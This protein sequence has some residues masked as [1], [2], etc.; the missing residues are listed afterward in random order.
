M[1]TPLRRVGKLAVSVVALAVV[2]WVMSGSSAFAKGGHGGGHG[3]GHHGGGHH[4]GGAHRAAGHRGGG[5]HVAAHH[6]ARRGA[7][8]HHV[9][10]HRAAGHQGAGRVAA[11]H[12]VN[13][14]QNGGRNVMA[15]RNAV[16]SFNGGHRA[17]LTGYGFGV[18]VNRTGYGFGLG[19]GYG[20]GYGGN[21]YWRRP[22]YGNYGGYGYGYGNSYPYNNYQYWNSP[23]YYGMSGTPVNSVASDP[24]T[25]WLSRVG[26][27]AQAVTDATGPSVQVISVFAGSPAEQA[28]LIT[29][30]VIHAANGNL[31]RYREELAQDIANT[32]PNGVLALSVRSLGTVSDHVVNLVVP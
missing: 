17:N 9:A 22:G 12:R 5:H 10:A 29:G 16:G 32:P 1:N 28:G 6:A 13:A 23:S 26:I 11:V 4:G 21:G 18:G 30:D 2:F 20:Y 25:G 31:T 24:T 7:G 27:N 19:A 14:Q 3:G 8:V 15:N